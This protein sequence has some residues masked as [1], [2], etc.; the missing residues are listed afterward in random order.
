LFPDENKLNKLYINNL[1]KKYTNLSL[2]NEDTQQK[3]KDLSKNIENKTSKN[4]TDM[5]E[6]IIPK[7]N[8]NKKIEDE[9]MNKIAS[10]IKYFKDQAFKSRYF[11]SENSDSKLKSEEVL[12]KYLDFI[13][14]LLLFD[15]IMKNKIIYGAEI[16]IYS[17]IHHLLASCSTNK[18]ILE[19]TINIDNP[20][21]PYGTRSEKCKISDQSQGY[22]KLMNGHFAEYRKDGWKTDEEFNQLKDEF[23]TMLDKYYTI[24]TVPEEERVKLTTNQTISGGSRKKSKKSRS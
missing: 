14:F 10:K 9:N 13:K 12:N 1:I 17:L 8:A 7:S 15:R 16:D 4:F 20:S 2:K 22:Y 18:N 24:F 11:S 19:T 3:I 23:N 5:L 21:I 6:E